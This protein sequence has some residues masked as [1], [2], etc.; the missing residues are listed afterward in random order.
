[1][2]RMHQGNCH[3]GSRTTYGADDHRRT[4]RPHVD[5]LVILRVLHYQIG[6]HLF[7][8]G[9]VVV[10]HEVVRRRKQLRLTLS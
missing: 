4:G 6:R 1:M 9:A 3:Q 7:D 2:N 8:I 5:I 10:K